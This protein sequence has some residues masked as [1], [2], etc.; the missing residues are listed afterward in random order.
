M[1]N[2]TFC[3]VI[4][5]NRRTFLYYANIAV[6]MVSLVMFERLPLSQPIN[7]LP[8]ASVEGG[9]GGS[10]VAPSSTVTVYECPSIIN[11]TV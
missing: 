7:F 3:T 5:L 11:V 1:G 10:T 8:E 6:I 9:K 2:D 4:C